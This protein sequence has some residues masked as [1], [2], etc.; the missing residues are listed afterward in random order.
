VFLRRTFGEA[1]FARSAAVSFGTAGDQLRAI[2]VYFRRRAARARNR[3]RKLEHLSMRTTE[4]IADAT[5]AHC[6][7][8]LNS[9]S[10]SCLI[11]QRVGR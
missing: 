3:V 10:R 7:S 8:Q 9:I 1:E 5:V 2:V 11:E 4:V 6:A